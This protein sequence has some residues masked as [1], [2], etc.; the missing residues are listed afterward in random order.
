[1]DEVQAQGLALVGKLR[2]RLSGTLDTRRGTSFKT[3]I[4]FQKFFQLVSKLQSGC[5]KKN[6]LLSTRRLLDARR[7]TIRKRKLSNWRKT[8]FSGQDKLAL[9]SILWKSERQTIEFFMWSTPV[10][11]VD[12]LAQIICC[13]SHNKLPICRPLCAHWI[14]YTSLCAVLALKS[15]SASS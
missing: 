7:I 2:K 9:E 10:A 14:Y 3:A 11:P 6:Q 8:T 15:S 12:C 5:F 1:M 13:F 4:W